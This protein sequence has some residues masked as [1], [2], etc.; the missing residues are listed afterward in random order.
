MRRSS[1][2]SKLGEKFYPPTAPHGSKQV[3]APVE[4]AARTTDSIL[5]LIAKIKQTGDLGQPLKEES[6]ELHSHL[7]ESSPVL[8]EQ[9]TNIE[10]PKATIDKR[11]FNV[12]YG[13]PSK[14]KHK[15]W[16]GDGVLEV[17]EKSL[18][19]KDCEGNIIGRGSGKKNSELE[20]GS[21]LFVGN[22]EI[23]I[24]DA[25]SS[26]G[27]LPTKRPSS[28]PPNP[29][30]KKAKKA[31]SHPALTFTTRSAPAPHHLQD[32]QPLTM[33]QPDL[34]HQWQFNKNGA[35]VNVVSVD[36]S[37]ARV[38]RP[39]QREG[40]TFLYRCIT[41]LRDPSHQGAILADEM[42]L[43]KTLQTITL[44]WTLLRQPL[45]GREPLLKKVLIVT[46][47][48]LARNWNQEFHRWLGHYRIHVF[49][50]DQKN[51]PKDF[52]HVPNVPVMIISYEMFVRYF[53]DI[54][55]VLFDLVV[56]DEG[57]R[58]KNNS[59]KAY[60]LLSQLP[61]KRRILLTGTPI[62]NDLQEFYALISLV[63][64]DI[65][66]SYAEFRKTYEES[67]VASRNLKVSQQ[68]WKEGESRA[69]QLANRTAGFILRRTHAILD[70]YLPGKHEVVVFCKPSDIQLELF[71]AA[72]S[73]WEGEEGEQRSVSHLAV[74]T[75]LK[76]ISSHPVLLRDNEC[77]KENDEL[78]E[79]LTAEL[80]HLT[81]DQVMIED[82]SKLSVVKALLHTIEKNNEKIVLVSYFTQTLDLLQA[83]CDQYGFQHCRLDGNTPSSRRVDIV[84]NFNSKHSQNRVFLLSAKAGGVGLNLVGAS[85]LVL[86]D[87]DW[88]PASDL[89][90]M[91]RVWRDGQRS[92]VH[93]YRLLTTG[94][95]E[96]KIFQRQ[97]KKAGL[98]EAVVDFNH[99][100][101]VR[102]SEEEL[103]DL[104]TLEEE[105][106]C[107]THGMLG[108][109]CAG[110]GE[111]PQP[112]VPQSDTRQCQLIP[113]PGQSLRSNQL[114]QW[115]HY[116]Q[117]LPLHMLTEM[118]LE[119]A[120]EFITFAF[121]NVVEA[122]SPVS[123]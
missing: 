60:T 79:L 100:S 36:P 27:E 65:L 111:V 58:L 91:A 20:E 69:E 26:P 51:K 66:G 19:L 54:T 41:G 18:T 102:L 35:P 123:S 47:S 22:K 76:K 32:Y 48:S 88:N 61:C 6:P 96:E 43:G 11:I 110:E 112:V 118:G 120:G 121:R 1:A 53:D 122:A 117:P 9:V 13:K 97:L 64:P 10:K 33:P 14:K 23:E 52:V 50:V 2:P 21:R 68:M 83:L 7:E 8:H 114:F 82:A 73:C 5:G 16:E 12:V 24:I 95:I 70:K 94:S 46:P 85:R 71:R 75:A 3:T 63:N 29:V 72:I 45:Y 107:L 99:T 38:L 28:S 116:R 31:P 84:N 37:L 30:R 80:S 92:T 56:C 89:Q 106:D 25:V 119:E 98:N 101:D 62:Q 109:E 74:I 39:H 86:F 57:H 4:N 34:D 42:G 108:C 105:V 93:I 77:D 113:Q 87:P 17:G 15:T 59:V 90:A 55:Q 44:I 49:T 40:V 115:Q 78:S 104:F 103:K 67:I 81:G